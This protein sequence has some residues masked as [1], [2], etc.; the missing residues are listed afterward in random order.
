MTGVQTCALRSCILL[1]PGTHSLTPHA[2]ANTSRRIG[3]SIEL[4]VNLFGRG[5]ATVQS[6][7]CGITVA[8]RGPHLGARCTLDGLTVLTVSDTGDSGVVMDGGPARLQSCVI[9]GP[10]RFGLQIGN[11]V[12]L[13]PPAH[14][15]PRPVIIAC[16][17][18]QTYPRGERAQANEIHT[19]SACLVFISNPELAKAAFCVTLTTESRVPQRWEC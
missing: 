8:I 5:Q 10:S 7:G 9:T 1:R 18:G 13:G 12:T 17:C 6:P 19:P 2:H 3:L 15:V 14:A 11:N 16:R 4:P